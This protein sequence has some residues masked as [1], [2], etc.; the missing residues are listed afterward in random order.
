MEMEEDVPQVKRPEKD[1]HS[2]ERSAEEKRFRGVLM[3]CC[4]IVTIAVL[5][6]TFASIVTQKNISDAIKN[7]NIQGIERSLGDIREELSNIERRLW[8]R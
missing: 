8:H 5:I 4:V 2:K 1:E 3:V 6:N 7:I